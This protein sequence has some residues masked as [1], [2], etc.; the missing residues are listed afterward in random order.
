MNGA[1]R[2]LAD[3]LRAGV[4][5]SQAD[6]QEHLG[7]VVAE[8]GQQVAGVVGQLRS[9]AQA[10]S[11]AHSDRIAEMSAHARES[12]NSLAEGVR[13][14]TAAIEQVTAAVRSAVTELAGAVGR[15][16]ERMDEGAGRIREAADRFTA[17]GQAMG[18]ALDRS[19]EASGQLAQSAA[20]LSSASRDVAAVVGDYRAAREA[21]ADLVDGLRGT[22]EAAK[23]DAATISAQVAQLE[24]AA[25]TLAAAEGQADEY[26]AKVTEVLAQAHSTFSSQMAET[27]RGA[28]A[29][30]HRHLADSTSLLA[31]T[32]AELDGTVIEF[33]PRHRNGG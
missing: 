3:E 21:F 24:A 25:Q 4:A 6:S 13:A 9:E 10:S 11:A 15:N 5:R 26:L 8:L 31:T 27:L 2:Q 14:Q 7:R 33:A 18:E 32:V 12:V 17:S 28:N 1:M 20:M 16:V 19:R 29:E 30:F 22:V 23:R